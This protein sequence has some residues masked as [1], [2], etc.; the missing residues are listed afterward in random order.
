MTD[1]EEP[2]QDDQKKDDNHN[3][4]TGPPP[5]PEQP[6]PTDTPSDI[7][8]PSDLISPMQD[9]KLTSPP[10]EVNPQ[11]PRVNTRSKSAKQTQGGT[12]Q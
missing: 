11:P 2:N 5:L 10:T 12:D 7:E 9:S 3:D 8:H 4:T 1:I 6:L